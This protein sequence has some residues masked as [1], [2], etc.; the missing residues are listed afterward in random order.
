MLCSTTIES[1]VGR[2]AITADATAIVMISWSGQVNGEV[3]ALLAEATQQ[4][5]AYFAGRLRQFD[6]PLQPAG[7]L[8]E[9]RV[10]AAMRQIP[11]GQTRTYGELAMAVGSAPRA[12]G[13]AC[14]KNPIP[15]V[16]PCHRVLARGGLGGYSGGAGLETKRWLLA[17]EGIAAP[18]VSLPAKRAN[19]GASKFDLI[20]IAASPRSSQ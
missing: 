6:L 8:F 7:S 1:P 12:I 3:T 15:I 17:L 5:D 19:P 18:V 10:W 4:L 16:I 13:G 2:L 20:R 9:R 14:G 11:H